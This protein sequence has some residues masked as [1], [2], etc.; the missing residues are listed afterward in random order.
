MGVSEIQ[1]PVGE[2]STPSNQGPAPATD[3][4]TR[5]AELEQVLA[6]DVGEFHSKNLGAEMLDLRRKIE[7]A[8][9]P[10]T[11]EAEDAGEEHRELSAEDLALLSSDDAETELS[12][13]ERAEYMPANPSDYLTPEV[14]GEAW[15]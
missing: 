5:I 2:T 12:P 14:D 8:E 9:K 11:A 1:A 10:E 3:P 7:S 6:T 15:T 4:A 13:E